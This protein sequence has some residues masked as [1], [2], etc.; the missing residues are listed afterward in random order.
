VEGSNAD[1]MLGM[2][3]RAMPRPHEAGDSSEWRLG[4]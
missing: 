1:A 3:V 4:S 2:P